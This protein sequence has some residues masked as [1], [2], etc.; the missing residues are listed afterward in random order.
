MPSGTMILKNASLAAM[1]ARCCATP[2]FCSNVTASGAVTKYGA[3]TTGPREFVPSNVCTRS[4]VSAK[5]F[6]G[7]L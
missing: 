4:S 2:P 3:T 7:L 6:S 1:P 5:N